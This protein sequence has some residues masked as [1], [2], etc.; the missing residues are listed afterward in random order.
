MTTPERALVQSLA[1][2]DERAFNEIVGRYHRS[3]VRLARNYVRSEAVA[4]EVAQ[5]AWCAVVTGIE[6]FEGRSSFK[7]WLFSIVVN[8]ARTRAERERRTTPFSAL[9]SPE[10]DGSPVAIEDRFAPDGAWSAP[11]RPW[12]DPERRTISL[13]LRAEL[14]EALDGLPERQRLVVTLRDVE[15]LEADEV[16]E[17]LD[18]SSGNER[19]LLH[20]GRSRLRAALEPALDGVALPV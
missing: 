16:C 5:D 10:E 17:L 15:G 9:A 13:E 3:L 6:R 18:L 1:A 4:E 11:P 14:R 8:K 12:E 20:R 19:V 2:G 7:T